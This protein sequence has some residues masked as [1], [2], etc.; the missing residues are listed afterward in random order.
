MNFL[1]HLYLSY[2]NEGVILGNFIADAV[3]GNK[4][5]HFPEDVVR[6]IRL[7]REID[8]YTDSHP[9]FRQGKARLSGRYRMFSGVIVDLYYDHFLAK[10]WVD[11]SDTDLEKCVASAYKLLL[12]H[13][14]ILPS[15]SR[16]ILPYMIAQNWLVGY[17]D[18]DRLTRV[19]QGMSRRSRFESGMEHAVDDLKKDYSLYESEFRLFFPDIISHIR[20]YRN[21]ESVF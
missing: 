13:Y 20:Q 7:H 10:N 11:Y 8:S 3:K 15:R 5:D 1:A 21:D 4:L 14:A 19:F 9:V 12:K 18:F 16:K 6:G 2:N 17:A